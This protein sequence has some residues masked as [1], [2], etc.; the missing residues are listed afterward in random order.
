MVRSMGNAALNLCLPGELAECYTGTSMLAMELPRASGASSAHTTQ[1][2]SPAVGS[3]RLQK[4]VFFWKGCYP[5]HPPSATVGAA[6]GEE[7]GN[8]TLP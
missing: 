7:R 3:C 4:A 2:L 8:V 5:A 6:S 1:T